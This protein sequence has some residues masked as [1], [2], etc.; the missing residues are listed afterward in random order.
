MYSE[1]ER[2]II[3]CS[4][5]YYDREYKK[6]TG[7]QVLDILEKYNMFPPEKFYAGKLTKNRFV[8]ST[9]Q[10]KE[11]MALAY[12]EK[13]I[14]GLDMSSGNSRKVADYWRVEWNFTFYKNSKLAVEPIFNPWNVLS[15]HSTHERM[16]NP[17]IYSEFFACIKDL[18]EL[19]DPF[20]ASV[21]D[22]NNKV[23]LMDQAHE[24]HFVP[25]RIQEVYWGNYFGKLHCDYFGIDKIK[26]IP[27]K[28]VEVIRNGVF[29]SLTDHVLEYESK[30]CRKERKNIKKYLLM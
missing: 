6:S 18:I 25:D 19:L 20:Y 2:P 1:N 8:Y 29:F 5:F 10:T 13:D 15:I 21:D 7:E 30:K 14:L 28:N 17:K 23:E 12:N 27:A 26:A 4:I 24:T 3:K 9:E 22:I 16:N 11:M